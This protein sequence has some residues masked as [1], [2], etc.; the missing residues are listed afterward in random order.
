MASSSYKFIPVVVGAP[1][2]TTVT[3]T[4]STDSG[5]NST[6]IDSINIDS[7]I[8]EKV[9]LRGTVTLK[10]KSANPS[11][12]RFTDTGDSTVYQTFNLPTNNAS[13]EL[14]YEDTFPVKIQVAGHVEVSINFK[15]L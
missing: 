15:L 14:D 3:S 11:Y 10:N 12:A 2:L 7:A 13:V 8:G 4:V 9:F 5:L 1:V 6:W